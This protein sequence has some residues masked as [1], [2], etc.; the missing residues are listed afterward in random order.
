MNWFDLVLLDL[1]EFA[2]GD[3]ITIKQD[4]IRKLAKYLPVFDDCRL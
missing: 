3:T 4:M 1:R 2:F